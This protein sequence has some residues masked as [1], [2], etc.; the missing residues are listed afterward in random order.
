MIAFGRKNGNLMKS[1]E[2]FSFTFKTEECGI[3]KLATE[4][5]HVMEKDFRMTLTNIKNMES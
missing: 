2:R 4:I 3:T 5:E 1:N